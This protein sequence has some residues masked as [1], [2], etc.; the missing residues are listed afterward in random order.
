MTCYLDQV[1]FK[2]AFVIPGSAL[3]SRNSKSLTGALYKYNHFIYLE[4]KMQ[5]KLLKKIVYLT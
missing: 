4:A 5:T 2:T 3:I 1:T